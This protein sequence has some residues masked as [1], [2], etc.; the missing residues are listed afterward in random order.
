MKYAIAR[1]SDQTWTYLT[2]SGE[3]TTDYGK[4]HLWD[5][6]TKASDKLSRLVAEH[7]LSLK[8]LQDK[9]GLTDLQI[10]LYSTG[11]WLEAV[12]DETTWR[13]NHN[14]WCQDPDCTHPDCIED[15]ECQ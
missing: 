1:I 7:A 6:V 5:C 11:Y 3:Y 9:S 15:D 10:V 13:R 8:D 2:E 14:T 12:E 4:A